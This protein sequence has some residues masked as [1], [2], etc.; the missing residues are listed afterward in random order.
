MDSRAQDRDLTLT[1]RN[2]AL[3]YPVFVAD[4]TDPELRTFVRGRGDAVIVLCDAIAPV[5]AIAARVAATLGRARVLPFA[6]GEAHKRWATVE[7]V[8]PWRAQIAYW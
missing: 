6:L 4:D 3:G 7:S 5:R 8:P 1:V 2:D